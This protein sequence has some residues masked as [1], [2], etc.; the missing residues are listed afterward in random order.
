MKLYE[1]LEQQLKKEP[2]FVT[3]DGELKK[4]V[5]LNKAQN[6]DEELI[7]LLL[8]N[9]DLKE[10]FFVKV[11]DILVFN[12]NIFS[13][14]LEQK[15]Y[16]KD[17]YTQYKNK[18]GLNIDGEYLKQRNDVALVW[19][20]K[21]CILEGGQSREEQN[22]EEIFFN[23]VLA[24]DE[25][26]HL[27]EPKVLTNSKR[28]DKD[29][30]K[31]L[32]QFNRDEDGFIIDNLIIK[33]NNLLALHTLK[34]EFAGK[35]KLIYIDP[36][37]NTGGDSFRYNDNFN[38]SAWLTFMKNRLVNAKSLLSDNGVILIQ[39]DDNE[40]AYLKVLMD[41]IFGHENFQA[42]LTTIVKTEGRRYGNVAKTHEYILL[43]SKNIND[44]EM[45]QMEIEGK[46]FSYED[47]FGGF[48]LKEL[49]NQNT[50][51]FN[52][53]NRPNLRYPFYVD[54]DNPDKNGLC[55]LSIKSNKGL[56]EVWPITINSNK[57]VWRWGKEK[58]GNETNKYLTARKGSDGVVRIY[59]KYRSS[60]TMPKTVWFETEFI[61]NKG[62]KEIQ[63]LFG[64]RAFSFPKAEALIKRIIEIATIE[65]EIVLDYHLGS[66]TTAA[67]AHK[68]GRQYIGVEQMEYIE[69]VAVERLKKVIEGEQ[70]GISKAV[71]WKGGGSFVYFELKKYNQT[72][73]DKIEASKN[74]E[75]L[76]DI[77]EQMKAKSFLNY[78][79]DIQEQ[80]KHLEEFKADSLK[81]QKQLLLKL[82]DLN[83]LYVNLSSLNDNDFACT[84]EEK[85]VTKDFY[86]IKD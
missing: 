45:F 7:G 81:N 74:T 37:Y 46:T 69:D 35:V 14:F 8:D 25:I 48:D 38:H 15:S 67:V 20:F 2:N 18:V 71:D 3:D 39:C 19:P 17:S 27:L 9:A 28:I 57:S 83:Q 34:E 24:Q 70:G 79:V 72:F 68:M 66:G 76:L 54:L 52:S 12:Q 82:L 55:K 30:E 73:I 31:P 58:S 53:T 23:E 1:T 16:L 44:T 40:Q 51:A 61:S 47:E 26:T 86:Q 4:W 49:R 65:S 59:Q 77:W 22:R 13:Q 64:N 56:T 42:N 6:F 5:V 36:P 32:K 33:G 29:G 43:Y 50:Q 62:T 63:S 85:A 21:D 75:E 41:E 60:T 84:D 11:K 10:K 78:N 80:E